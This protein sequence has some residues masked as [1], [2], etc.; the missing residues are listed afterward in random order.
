MRQCTSCVSMCM[1]VH[2]FVVQ[3]LTL[4]REIFNLSMFDRM[5]DETVKCST[6]LYRQ[7]SVCKFDVFKYC[8]FFSLA[9]VVVVCLLTRLFLVNIFFFCIFHFQFSCVLCQIYLMKSTTRDRMGH[10]FNG[11][12][13]VF[14][15]IEMKFMRVNWRY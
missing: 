15:A 8:F 13:C 9:S 1:C 4:S 10:F 3:R 5:Y 14:T 12:S 11:K 6:N 2:Y 7:C